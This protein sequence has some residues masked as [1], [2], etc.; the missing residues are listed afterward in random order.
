VA[1]KGWRSIYSN[2]PLQARRR[3]NQRRQN[4]VGRE[5]VDGGRSADVGREEA[6]AR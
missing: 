3:E 1:D 2:A 5:G 6:Q 4:G